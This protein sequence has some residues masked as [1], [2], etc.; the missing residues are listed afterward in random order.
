MMTEKMVLVLFKDGK[1]GRFPLHLYLGACMAGD[2]T[3]YVIRGGET[4]WVKPGESVQFVE[5]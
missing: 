4:V 1:S 2:P 5:A 3:A